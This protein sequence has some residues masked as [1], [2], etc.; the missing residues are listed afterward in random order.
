[1]NYNHRLYKNIIADAIITASYMHVLQGQLKKI[2]AP[3]I[4]HLPETYNW[5]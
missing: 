5:D 4:I 1:M 2:A 3:E